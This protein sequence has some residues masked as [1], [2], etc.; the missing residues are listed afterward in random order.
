MSYIL[1]VDDEPD[2]CTLLKGIFE[3]D[4]STV[5][6]AVNSTEAL[7]FISNEEPDLIILDIWLRNS[8][9]D[10]IEILKLITKESNNIPVI[11]ISGHGNIEVAVEAVKLGAY[12]FIEKPFNTGQILLVKIKQLSLSS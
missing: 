3:D 2:I 7:K 10:G 8:D 5:R 1:V 4:G 12:D 6:M 9:L 11:I